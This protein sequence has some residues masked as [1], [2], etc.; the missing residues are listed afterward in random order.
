MGSPGACTLL[1]HLEPQR[2]RL[3]SGYTK[4]RFTGAHEPDQ[5]IECEPLFI[6]QC[7]RKVY[8]SI[9]LPQITL[10]L[11]FRSEKIH[12]CFYKISRM[13]AREHGSRYV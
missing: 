10:I 1:N 4:L 11:L 12:F 8:F 9:S 7:N 13:H 2:R 6:G 3:Q 5:T